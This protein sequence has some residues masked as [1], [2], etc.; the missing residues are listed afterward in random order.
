MLG[1]RPVALNATKALREMNFGGYEG[2]TVGEVGRRDSGMF[3]ERRDIDPDIA[4]PEGE[5]FVQVYQRVSGF[6][7][8][9]IGAGRT[10][11]VLVVAHNGSVRALLLNL[12]ALPLTSFGAFQIAGGSLAIVECQRG[13]NVL[14]VYNHTAYDRT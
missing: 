13:R 2:L 10:D 11:T 4:P 14:K 3:M 7:R 1:D 12:L 5:S 9:T 6:V 8:A